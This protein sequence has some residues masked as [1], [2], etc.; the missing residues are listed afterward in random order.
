MSITREDVLQVARLAKLR[1]RD[2]EIDSLIHDLAEILD[3]M[4]LLDELDTSD[5]TPTAHVG[6]ECAPLREDRVLPVLRTEDTLSEAPRRGGDGFAV[7]AFV[8]EG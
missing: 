8:D 7:P 4:A 6:V 1:L 2:A 3:Y 5:V